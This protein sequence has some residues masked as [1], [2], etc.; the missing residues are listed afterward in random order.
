M[1]TAITVFSDGPV[2]AT[3][4]SANMMVGKDLRVSKVT[5]SKRSSHFGPKPASIPSSSPTVSPRP[6]LPGVVRNAP[7]P[8][9]KNVATT[10]QMRCR[11]ASSIV[12]HEA[13]KLQPI[14]QRVY[15]RVHAELPVRIDDLVADTPHGEFV[16]VPVGGTMETTISRVTLV[17]VERMID[18]DLLTY[19]SMLDGDVTVQI[20]FDGPRNVEMLILQEEE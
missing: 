16:S 19:A 11:G 12:I 13:K 14:K 9:K 4:A 10:C 8:A 17:S 1:I 2:R 3:T 15:E 6:T 5:T 20:T 18:N 7:R